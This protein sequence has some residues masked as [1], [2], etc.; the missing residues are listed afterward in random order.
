MNTQ[1]VNSQFACKDFFFGR[2]TDHSLSS[3]LTVIWP[4]GSQAL[5]DSR[6][7]KLLE[8]YFGAFPV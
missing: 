2:N 1:V 6:L 4:A 8:G 7:K 5:S 3:R